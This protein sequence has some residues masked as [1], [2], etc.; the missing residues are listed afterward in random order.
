MGEEI[1]WEEFS[2]MAVEAVEFGGE[3]AAEEFLERGGQ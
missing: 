3:G 2:G 1:S